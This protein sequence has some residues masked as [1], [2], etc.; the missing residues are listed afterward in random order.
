MK[1]YLLF[2]FFLF[3]CIAAFAQGRR[4]PLHNSYYSRTYSDHL[5]QVNN[6]VYVGAC[7]MIMHNP[8]YGSNIGF[9]GGLLGTINEYFKMGFDVFYADGPSNS[10]FGY[11]TDKPNFDLCY[12]GIPAEFT[13]VN[14]KW[15]GMH[16]TLANSFGF[17]SIE[18]ANH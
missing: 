17:S 11:P 5:N 10:S 8:D 6:N 18:D 13:L 15:F 4:P 12:F 14:R 2:L 3:S 16:L 7:S 9:T 1:K